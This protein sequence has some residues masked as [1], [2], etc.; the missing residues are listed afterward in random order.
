MPGRPPQILGKNLES[1]VFVNP[2]GASAEPGWAPGMKNHHPQDPGHKPKWESSPPGKSAKGEEPATRCCSLPPRT[3]W[4]RATTIFTLK[5]P[6][7]KPPAPGSPPLRGPPVP[8]S[9]NGGT[10]GRGH[11]A[12]PK[13][14]SANV[15]ANL[16]E[17][18][19]LKLPSLSKGG[20]SHPL[21][22]PRGSS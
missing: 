1:F 19:A 7:R 14:H 22:L 20:D 5:A 11:R 18:Q 9:H 4:A 3:R 2:S 17:V 16:G 12:H 15:A 10:V 21:P 6:Q 13:V 8:T